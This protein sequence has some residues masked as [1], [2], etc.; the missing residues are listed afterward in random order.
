MNVKENAILESIKRTKDFCVLHSTEFDDL[1]SFNSEVTNLGALE[2][3]IRVQNQVLEVSTHGYTQAKEDSKENLLKVLLPMLKMVQ[4]FASM[5]KDPILINAVN[6]TESALRT[7]LQNILSDT[8]RTILKLCH[9][10]IS[11]LKAYGLTDAMLPILSAAIDDFSTKLDGTPTY[12]GERKAARKAIKN[13]FAEARDILKPKLDKLIEL[14]RY[15]HPDI[16]VGYK[17]S[18]KPE[19]P[20][21]R[22]LALR[23]VVRETGTNLPIAGATIAIARTDAPEA[24]KKASGGGAL[25]KGVKISA[26]KGG[27]RVKTLEAGEY[28]ITASKKGYATQTITMY[29][30]DGERT[31]AQL[32]LSAL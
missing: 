22:T 19:T 9:E 15:S 14:K 30:N 10:H 29:I 8:C 32:E 5:S 31:D 25:D 12:K 11:D 20:G 17:N 16:Y 28:T 13:W 6:Y 23:V 2:E 21:Y 24:G 3:N 4:A 18:R 1:P 27:I 7:M 26:A